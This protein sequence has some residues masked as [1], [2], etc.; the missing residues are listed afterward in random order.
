[1]GSAILPNE[2][3]TV[4]ELG[5]FGKSSNGTYRSQN[6]NDDLAMTCVSTSAFFESP[7]FWELV[8]D[9]LDRLP[10]EYL[11][12]AYLKFLD[13]AYLGHDSGFNHDVLRSLNQTAEL[14]KPGATKRFDENSIEVIANCPI[15]FKLRNRKFGPYFN[16]KVSIPSYAA[17][18]MICKKLATIY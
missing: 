2:F 7:N 14:K 18:Y 16:E 9:E 17:I 12:E 13:E 1:M 6:G 4:H 8:N 11:V 15:E 5:S 3:K 10:K